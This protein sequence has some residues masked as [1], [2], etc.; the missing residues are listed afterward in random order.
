LWRSE[1]EE[2]KC[3]EEGKNGTEKGGWRSTTAWRS[4]AAI[5]EKS[6]G[7]NP[8]NRQRG[9]ENEKPAGSEEEEGVT[10]SLPVR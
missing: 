8:L 5:C 9:T 2:K 4:G 6:S 7:Q 3:D 10:V 1:K